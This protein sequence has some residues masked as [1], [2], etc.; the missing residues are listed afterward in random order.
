M[1]LQLKVDS[2][3]G[4]DESLHSLYVK[5][6]NGYTLDVDGVEDTTG[7]KTA[8]QKERD[9]RKSAAQRLK[10]LEAKEEEAQR[11]ILEEQG[12]YKELTEKERNEKIAVQQELK[13]LKD[14]IIMSK[15]D[16]MTRDIATSMTSDAIE[17]ESIILALEKMTVID[18]ENISFGGTVDEVKQKL[19]KFVRSKA[20]DANDG[21]NNRGGGN[22][23]TIERSAFEAMTPDKRSE[24][25]KSGGQ[26]K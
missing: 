1:A 5:G 9:E 2:L 23:Q 12:K 24:Y 3:E 10:E 20:N 14:E 11:K 16:V 6:D 4:L 19:S 26:I 17:Q 7:L 18:G 25:I 22:V 15:R 21:G 13:K 8:L